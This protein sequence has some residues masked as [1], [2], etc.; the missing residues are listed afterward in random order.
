M[1]FSKFRRRAWMQPRLFCASASTSD[2][3]ELSGP[4]SSPKISICSGVRLAIAS[5]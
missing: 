5:W 1:A 2:T 4:P 3:S